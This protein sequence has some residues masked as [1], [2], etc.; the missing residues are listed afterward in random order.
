MAEG[1]SGIWATS[2]MPRRGGILDMELDFGH[3]IIVVALEPA[4]RMH[5]R[6]ASLQ[7]PLTRVSD[8]TER[9]GPDPLAVA[10]RQAQPNMVRADNVRINHEHVGHQED[11]FRI[12]GAKGTGPSRSASRL[13]VAPDGRHDRIG[14]EL[15]RSGIV[16]R[17]GRDM[18]SSGIR[19]K[20]GSMARATRTPPPWRVRRRS[21]I[22]LRVR[23]PMTAPRSTPGT[24]RAEPR[25]MASTAA[26]NPA[27]KTG[28]AWRS[29]S[30]PATIPTTPACQ[31][32]PVTRAKACSL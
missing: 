1:N 26:S 9:D 12:P 28:F 20:R 4:R 10:R 31:P 32:S 17:C 6:T 19:P 8:G 27:T 11:R 5:A 13:S 21:P 30:R 3:P 22:V 18:L 16:S 29:F 25:P 15:A 14:D 7:Q 23:R 2:V 24:E